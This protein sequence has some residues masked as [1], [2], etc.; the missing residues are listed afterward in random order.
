MPGI[1]QRPDRPTSYRITLE[2]PEPGEGYERV[3]VL[4]DPA[5]VNWQDRWENEHLGARPEL[6]RHSMMG[7]EQ[8]VQN[9]IFE[10]ALPQ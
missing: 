3:K 5:A 9:A 4:V 10:G 1:E 7:L 8:P 6:Q 2:D